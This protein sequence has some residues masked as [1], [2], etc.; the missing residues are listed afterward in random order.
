MK[1][2]RPLKKEET[3][4]EPVASNKPVK[5]KLT[6]VK[7]VWCFRYKPFLFSKIKTFYI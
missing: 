5:R 1:G 7:P 6:H 3:V 4:W 2:L